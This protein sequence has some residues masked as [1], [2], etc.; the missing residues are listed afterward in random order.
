MSSNFENLK[1]FLIFKIRKFI[2][3]DKADVIPVFERRKNPAC[4][5][6]V[7]WNG[8]HFSEHSDKLQV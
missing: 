1:D 2:L 7:F 5:E 4:G 3:R 8:M 6:F